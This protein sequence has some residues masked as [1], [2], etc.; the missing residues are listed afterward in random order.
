MIVIN[1]FNQLIEFIRANNLN[2]EQSKKLIEPCLN[3]L[4]I[5][6]YST[7]ED[8]I[9]VVDAYWKEWKHTIERPL[10]LGLDINVKI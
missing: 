9:K 4:I 1:T 3:V 5:L 2:V 6:D 10:F 7:T 8:L